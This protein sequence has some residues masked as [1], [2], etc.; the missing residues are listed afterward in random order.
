MNK[1]ETAE[2]IRVMQAFVDGG[3][4]EYVHKPM[5]AQNE[6]FSIKEPCWDWNLCRYRV[7]PKPKELWI[8]DI[9]VSGV[10]LLYAYDNET[11]AAKAAQDFARSGQTRR[12]RKFVEVLDE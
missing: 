11:D 6:W 10:C 9:D 12:I 2:A 3:E 7:K 5:D 8:A 1:Q 4:I